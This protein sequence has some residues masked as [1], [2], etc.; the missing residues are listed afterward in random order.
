MFL[1]S[2]W[3]VGDLRSVLRLKRFEERL[4]ITWIIVERLI[5]Q[6][7]FGRHTTIQQI[8]HD[9]HHVERHEGGIEQTTDHDER[10]T[11]LHAR[12]DSHTE[13]HW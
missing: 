3:M 6:I 7:D 9:R 4:R 12:A 8:L 5:T 11:A 10:H 13:Y 2:L 1:H